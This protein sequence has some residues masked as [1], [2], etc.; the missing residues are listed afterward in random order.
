M[1]INEFS[2]SIVNAAGHK[3]KVTLCFDD[4]C[5]NGHDT[6]SITYEDTFEGR[7]ISGGT[8][9]ETVEKY[10]PEYRELTR[11][12]LCST[13]GPLHYIANSMYWAKQ[14]NLEHARACAIWGDAKL[15]DFTEENLKARLPAL[16]EEFN[17]LM[18]KTFGRERAP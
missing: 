8:N 2:K 7:F 9:H 12:H 18:V 1:K 10:F 3:I 4:R 14:G 17:S 16:L 5:R 11:F 6:F 13:D 15:E